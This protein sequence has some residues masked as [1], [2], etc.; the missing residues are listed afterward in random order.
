MK[1]GLWIGGLVLALFVRGSELLAEDVRWRAVAIPPS[2]ETPGATLDR[3]VPVK[4]QSR[5]PS[6]SPAALSGG[7]LPVS[8]EVAEPRAEPSP[9]PKPSRPAPEIIAVS[10][11]LSTSVPAAADDAEETTESVFAVDRLLRPSAP[12]RPPLGSILRTSAQ[13][14]QPLAVV[15]DTSAMTPNWNANWD[16]PS[17]H[18][19]V[20]EGED[21]T[22]FTAAASPL[23][24]RRFYVGGEY[25]LW[26]IKGDPVPVLATTSSPN[27]SGILGAPTTTVLFGGNSLNGNSP[28]SGGRFWAGY[29]LDCNQ[30]KAIEVGGFFLGPRASN[31]TTDSFTN[32]VIGRPFLEA[33]NNQESAQLTATP[34][35]A[36]G[37]L[38]IHAPTMLW[39]LQGNLR[40]LLCC[41]CNYRISAFAGFRNINL[42]ESLTIREDI[43]GLSTAPP[44]FT[45]QTITV[46]D[47]FA[48]QNHFYGGQIGADARWYWGRWS[49]D[50]RGQLAIGGNSQLLDI[51]GSQRFVAPNG[52]V[53]NFTG[54]LLAEPS[55]IG[56]FHHSAFSFV[57]QIGVNVGYQILP[58]LRG[59]VGYNFLY[60]T[61]VIRPGTSIDRSLDVTQIPNFPLNP[62]PAPVPGKHPAPVFNET[63]FWAQGITFGLEMTY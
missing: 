54:G 20:L 7:I 9:R 44:P 4:S 52:T 17:S 60:W 53:Q 34:G 28:F 2:E 29:W 14:P 48:T 21:P 23:N 24:R 39:G 42:D 5:Y 57:P 56:H 43:Q 27:D 31:F 32:P 45:S 41:G 37:A 50:G 22:A 63:N 26:W 10:A 62:E 15:P 12:P 58:G 6:I 11:P 51:S 19:P 30:T 16:G 1:N 38:T 36:I 13:V 46:S 55:N 8:F 59:F 33:N 49:I 35:V 25:L 18:E 40:C 3:P 47:S 61:N